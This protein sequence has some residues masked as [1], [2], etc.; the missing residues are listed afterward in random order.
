VVIGVTASFFLDLPAGASIVMCNAVFFA[1]V[2]AFKKAW[3]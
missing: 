3:S 1:A 2:L